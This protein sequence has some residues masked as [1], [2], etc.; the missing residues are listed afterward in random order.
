MSIQDRHLIDVVFKNFIET[1]RHARKNFA[2]DDLLALDFA[3]GTCKYFDYQYNGLTYVGVVHTYTDSSTGL[4][5]LH[6]RLSVIFP[7]ITNVL[8]QQSSPTVPFIENIGKGKYDVAQSIFESKESGF[9]VLLYPIEKTTRYLKVTLE[10]GEP[11]DG[12]N[13]KL[14]VK[15]VPHFVACTLK[16]PRF[17]NRFDKDQTSVSSTLA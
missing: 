16:V 2:F 4:N 15:V 13:R 10:H 5:W 12:L 1:N 8:R 17:V 7:N 3:Q 6:I 14:G 11:I 9:H